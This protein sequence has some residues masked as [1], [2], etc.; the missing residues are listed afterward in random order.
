MIL[1]EQLGGELV[2]RGQQPQLLGHCKRLLLLLRVIRR[3]RRRAQLLD[4]LL[5]GAVPAGVGVED[6]PAAE[7][8]RGCWATDH[9]PV[10]VGGEERLL[11]SHLPEVVAERREPARHRAGAVVDAHEHVVLGG[12]ELQATVEDARRCQQPG[13]RECFTAVHLVEVH[14]G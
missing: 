12:G 5:L 3:L 14:A 8:I 2:D 7:G 13:L 10:L 6:H 4:D 1:G 9:E 11:Q